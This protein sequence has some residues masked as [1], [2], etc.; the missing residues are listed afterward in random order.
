MDWAFKLEDWLSVPAIPLWVVLLIVL[1]WPNLLS[2]IRHFRE[3]RPGEK[4]KPG[5]LLALDL[6]FAICLV[7]LVASFIRLAP[8]PPI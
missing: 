1:G 2:R 8:K 7:A 4:M 3:A 6:G 5:L